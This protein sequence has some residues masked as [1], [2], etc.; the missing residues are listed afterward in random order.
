MGPVIL[1]AIPLFPFQSRLRDSARSMDRLTSSKPAARG[2]QSVSMDDSGFSRY[3]LSFS[4]L[5]VTYAQSSLLAGT[6]FAPVFNAQSGWAVTL[7][8]NSQAPLSWAPGQVWTGEKLDPNTFLLQ[9][10]CSS[11]DCSQNPISFGG[12]TVVTQMTQTGQAKPLNHRFEADLEE[13][14]SRSS[15]MIV[16]LDPLIM[17]HS[18]E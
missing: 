11:G 15:W 3:T 7:G 1:T 14:L 5:Y 10:E 6:S 16:P 2:S 18:L 4:L 12:G 13:H 17:G 8:V 9:F